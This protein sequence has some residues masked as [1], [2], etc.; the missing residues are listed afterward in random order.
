MAKVA[1]FDAGKLSNLTQK[2]IVRAE[3][4]FI[5]DVALCLDYCLVQSRDLVQFYPLL[6]WGCCL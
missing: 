4:L 6:L 3:R 5:D 2:L 1:L